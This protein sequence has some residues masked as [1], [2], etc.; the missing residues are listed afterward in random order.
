MRKKHLLK[1]CYFNSQREFYVPSAT[2]HIIPRCCS[3]TLL[4]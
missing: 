1:M 4:I 2:A 3:F